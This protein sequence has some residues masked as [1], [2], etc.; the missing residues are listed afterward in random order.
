MKQN[1]ILFLALGV[2]VGYLLA[3]QNK[4]VLPPQTTEGDPLIGKPL[5]RNH[6]VLIAL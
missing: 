1:P 2:A 6:N 3:N 4:T 5:K